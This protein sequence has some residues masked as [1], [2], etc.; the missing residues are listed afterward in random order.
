M[1]LQLLFAEI[2]C[3]I[4]TN[5]ANHCLGFINVHSD[6]MI[7]MIYGLTDISKNSGTRN[8]IGVPIYADE[9]QIFIYQNAFFLLV[10]DRDAIDI[11]VVDEAIL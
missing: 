6:N 3:R 9:K 4:L 8:I 1:I 11:G 10:S 5:E 2:G 7:V